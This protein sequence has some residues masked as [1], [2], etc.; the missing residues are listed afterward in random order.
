MRLRE[1]IYCNHEFIDNIIKKQK[2]SRP[3]KIAYKIIELLG[4]IYVDLTKDE[5]RERIIKNEF[6]K[7][8]SK[9]NRGIHHAEDWVSSFNKSDV[10][11]EVFFI[12]GASIENY[13]EIREQYGCLIISLDDISY[14]EVL[15]KPGN[16]SLIP[17]RNRLSFETNYKNSWDDVFRESPVCPVNAAIITD[18]F[19]FT[20]KFEDCKDQSLHAIL[21]SI[22]PEDLKISF[23]LTLF[24]CNDNGSFTKE[25]AQLIIDEIKSLNLC[26]D[27]KVTI[28]SHT[29]KSTTH[30]R[31]ILT[32]YHYITSGKGFN[33]IDKNG[34][35]EQTEG[36]VSCVFLNIENILGNETVKH[37]YDYTQ[38]WLKQILNNK[39]SNDCSFIIGD[40]VNRLFNE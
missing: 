37:H 10:T 40:N 20:D 11:D 39:N 7:I 38:G 9:N 2:K 27:I 3:H 29:K 19:M 21:R 25:K 15:C 13:K 17:T 4:E 26:Q 28:V 32:N 22:V 33:I 5:L 6:Y 18:N 23:H 24:Y 35:Q 34:I 36:S 31:K 12:K 16:F 8:L 14:L 30:D 1:R